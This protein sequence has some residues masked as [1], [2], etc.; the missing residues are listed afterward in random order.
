LR[1]TPNSPRGVILHIQPAVLQAPDKAVI[2]RAGDFRSFDL[3]V[4]SAYPTSCIA[5]PDKAVI[6][7]EALRRSIAKRGLYGAESK[8]PEHVYFDHAVRSFSTTKPDS[9]NVK[10]ACMAAENVDVVAGHSK[11]LPVLVLGSGKNRGGQ[12]R[13]GLRWLKGC[14]RHE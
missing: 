4:F 6:L 14:E 5:T 13:R 9:A 12:A 3:F 10:R 1:N 8:D 7:S 11:M 2:L